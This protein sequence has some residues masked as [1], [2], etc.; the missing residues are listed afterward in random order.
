MKKVEIHSEAVE[1]VKKFEVNDTNLGFGKY[2]APIMI[3][4]VYEKGE[5]RDLSLLPTVLSN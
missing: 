4:A 2:V 1:R 3:Q 5:W